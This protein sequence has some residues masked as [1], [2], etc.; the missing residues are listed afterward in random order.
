MEIQI[1]T[2]IWADLQ[3][4]KEV[5]DR[6]VKE[7]LNNKLD[8][9][10][11]KFTKDAAEGIIEVSIDKNSRSLFDWK[12][13]ASLDWKIFRFEREEFKKLDDLINHLFDKF[14]IELSKM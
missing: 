10:L 13:Q 4:S 14:K 8:N 1:K 2:H 6:L 11:N 12:I 5:I 9:Y 3:G 7:N